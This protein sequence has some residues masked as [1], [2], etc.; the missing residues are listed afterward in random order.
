MT[1]KC[2]ATIA[3]TAAATPEED[4]PAEPEKAKATAKATTKEKER[5][6]DDAPITS[7]LDPSRL[8]PPAGDPG[9]VRRGGE[10]Q[11][12]RRQHRDHRRVRPFA[13]AGTTR[14]D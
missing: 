7:P 4:V 8:T 14:R 6:R 12:H 11:Q 9:R 3:A 1:R 5:G 13:D 10:E 2:E